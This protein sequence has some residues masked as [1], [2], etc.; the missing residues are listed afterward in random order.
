MS[1]QDDDARDIRALL[2]NTQAWLSLVEGRNDL[3]TTDQLLLAS[4]NINVALTIAIG[5]QTGVLAKQTTIIGEQPI[6]YEFQVWA[7]QAGVPP[8]KVGEVIRKSIDK[9]PDGDW[10]NRK[11]QFIKEIRVNTNCGLK[12]AK[13]L[14]D[15]CSAGITEWWRTS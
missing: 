6:P 13:D 3:S 14:A 2:E 7:T 12:D 5:R 8:T 10:R 9:V 11:I 1:E 4:I 15:L